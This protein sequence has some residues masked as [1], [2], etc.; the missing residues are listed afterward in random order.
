MNKA[1][2]LLVILVLSLY[3]LKQINRTSDS[4][5]FDQW[6]DKN[7]KFKTPSE[8]AYRRMIFEANL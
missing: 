5:E 7:G 6:K 3:G 4:S 2:P 8:E 1:I